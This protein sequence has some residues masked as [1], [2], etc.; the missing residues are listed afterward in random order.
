MCR[1]V[2]EIVEKERAERDREI[3]LKM[4]AMGKLSYEE[5][6]AII[7]IFRYRKPHTTAQF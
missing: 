7:N 5:I 4:I 2:E 6:S 1:I 3:A